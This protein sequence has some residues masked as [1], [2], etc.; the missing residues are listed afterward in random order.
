[1]KYVIGALVGIIWGCI[2]AFINCSI[3]KAAIKKNKDSAMLIANLLRITVDIVLLGIIVLVRNLIPFS[4]ELALVGTVAAP[5]IRTSCSHSKWRQKS[6]M[7]NQ[8][9]IGADFIFIKTN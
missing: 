6:K 8:H 2:G 7:R 3:T 1:M 9:L 5:S 4:F